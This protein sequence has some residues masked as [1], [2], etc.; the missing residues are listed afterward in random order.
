[1]L[2]TTSKY[3]KHLVEILE[4]LARNVVEFLARNARNVVD[5]TNI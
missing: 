5:A 1:M 4:F 3:Y 2:Q